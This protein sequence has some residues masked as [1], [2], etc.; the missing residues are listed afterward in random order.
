MAAHTTKS[1]DHLVLPNR[2]LRGPALPPREQRPQVTDPSGVSVSEL[3]ARELASVFF[4]QASIWIDWS[5]EAIAATITEKLSPVS[6]DMVRKWRRP[7]DRET[8]SYAQICALGPRFRRLL[9]VAESR[10]DGAW[11]QSLMDLLKAA[12]DLAEE[13]A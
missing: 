2:Q 8:P 9:R 12:G 13:I 11:R 6:A 7:Q 1:L 3:D 4:D 5:N 10:H